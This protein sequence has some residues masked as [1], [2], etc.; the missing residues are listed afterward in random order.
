MDFHSTPVRF[1]VCNSWKTQ[2]KCTNGYN[3]LWNEC[4]LSS[5]TEQLK[6][7]PVLN[8]GVCWC[9]GNG[10]WPDPVAKSSYSSKPGSVLWFWTLSFKIFKILN[11]MLYTMLSKML[12]M[13]CS[14]LLTEL[15]WLARFHSR[16]L[17]NG[18]S[19]NASLW[20][21]A[22]LGRGTTWCLQQKI[23]A[24]ICKDC[25]GTHNCRKWQVSWLGR[26]IQLYNIN[27]QILAGQNGVSN[28]S[29]DTPLG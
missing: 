18:V 8:S 28:K 13:L 19:R 10:K 20:C 3:W 15:F 6:V 4:P 26:W 16:L 25:H 9:S 23:T 27:W 1:I 21:N 7:V 5:E 12:Q 17:H 11:T 2:T 29:M 24:R 14:C 22:R